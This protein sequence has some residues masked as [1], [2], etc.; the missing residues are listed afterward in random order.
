MTRRRPPSATYKWTS[1]APYGLS[2]S[3]ENNT[4]KRTPL[5]ITLDMLKE[6]F[7]DYCVVASGEVVP[8]V[9]NIY[10]TIG[11]DDEGGIPTNFTTLTIE[12]A[13]DDE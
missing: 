4:M 8:E 9:D 7:R 11:D 13:D 6:I 10:V 5:T 1:L 3:K 12:F 2:F